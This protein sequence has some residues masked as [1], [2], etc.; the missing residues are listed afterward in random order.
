MTRNVWTP[1]SGWSSGETRRFDWFQPD[2]DSIIGRG[3]SLP[4]EAVMEKVRSLS[5]DDR[6]WKRA[7]A[8]GLLH[9]HSRGVIL[10]RTR[11]WASHVGDDANLYGDIVLDTVLTA[12][13]TFL[14]LTG[15][16]NTLHIHWSDM[17]VTNQV[18]TSM[19]NLALHVLEQREFL[20]SALWVIDRAEG[21]DTQAHD[22][23][24]TIDA[25][26]ESCPVLSEFY[27]RLLPDRFHTASPTGSTSW[28]FLPKVKSSYGKLR[29][30]DDSV[31]LSS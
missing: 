17:K 25:L 31:L 21:L 27:D 18:Q 26:F 4:N 19:R 13:M 5:T 6:A 7:A 16:R 23:V 29:I 30:V 9:R 2:I 28:W 24:A 14:Q 15:L 20:E 22:A 11:E 8:I 3:R 1:E 12:E 10:N